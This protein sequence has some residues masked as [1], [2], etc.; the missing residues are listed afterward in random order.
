[1]KQI[2]LDSGSYLLVEVPEDAVDIYADNDGA[3]PNFIGFHIQS[4]EKPYW[5]TEAIPFDNAELIGR[6]SELS[7][8]HWKRIVAKPE[9]GFYLRYPSNDNY[10]C[11]TPTESGHS[12]IESYRMKP[13]GTLILKKQ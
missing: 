12:L 6:C 1:M 2:T 5:H 8:W 7:E 3:E 4:V 9:Y 13:H 11:S 10:T